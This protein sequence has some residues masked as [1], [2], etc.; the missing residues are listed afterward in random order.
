MHLEELD[1]TERRAL[2][3]ARY[4]SLETFRRDG[5]GVATPV[6][7]AWHAGEIWVFTSADAGKVKRVRGRPTSTVARCDVRGGSVGPRIDTSARL[8]TDPAEIRAGYAALRARYGWQMWLLDLGARLSGRIDRRA[9]IA[10]RPLTG[11]HQT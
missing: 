3:D 1:E 8:V 6:W 10:L 5:R 11:H 7:C 4:I 9:L 2:H